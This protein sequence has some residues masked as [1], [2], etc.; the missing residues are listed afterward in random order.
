MTIYTVHLP[1][2]GASEKA[3]MTSEAPALLALVFPAFWLLWHRLWFALVVYL[4][5]A[6]IFSLAAEWT[7]SVALGVVAF[8]PGIFLFFEGR[9]LLRARLERKGWRFAGVVDA[10]SV[11]TADLR[12]FGLGSE[13][14]PDTNRPAVGKTPATPLPPRRPLDE[15]NG[16]SIGIFGQ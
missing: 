7:G 6:A 2:D 3:R 1:A 13:T 9:Q 14:V 5:L 10:G 12:Y 15:D 11:E 8:L 4:L 16:P